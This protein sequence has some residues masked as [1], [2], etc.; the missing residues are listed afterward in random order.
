MHFFFIS[1]RTCTSEANRPIGLC[2]QAE[3]T[4]NR[5]QVH[6]G[7]S[8]I[9]AGNQFQ[10]EELWTQVLSQHHHRAHQTHKGMKRYQNVH[11]IRPC[12]AKVSQQVFES[13]FPRGL[14]GNTLLSQN[15]LLHHNPLAYQYSPFVICLEGRDNC[16][17]KNSI[18]IATHRE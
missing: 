17:P 5:C 9:R 15:I 1:Y 12:S 11:H 7:K 10:R 18:F 14:G 2:S 13:I 16:T 3:T 8:E 4:P 6:C